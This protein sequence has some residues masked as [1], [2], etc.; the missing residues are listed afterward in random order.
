MT[1]VQGESDPGVTN[2]QVLPLPV[3]LACAAASNGSVA[4]MYIPY[5]EVTKVESD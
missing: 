2:S 5:I 4:D 3:V 1:R